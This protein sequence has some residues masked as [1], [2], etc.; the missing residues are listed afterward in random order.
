LFALAYLSAFFYRH[1]KNKAQGK[2][3]QLKLAPTILSAL[4]KVLMKIYD[5][6]LAGT[7]NSNMLQ[8]NSANKI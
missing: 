7:R 8:S 3:V 2:P 5:F 1:G 4:I 6:A